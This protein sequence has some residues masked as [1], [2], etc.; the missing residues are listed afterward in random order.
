MINSQA[1]SKVIS[2]KIKQ[3]SLLTSFICG[4][5]AAINVNASTVTMT[6]QAESYSD[7]SGI[8]TETTT[9]TGGGLNVTGTDIGDWLVYPQVTMPCT[10]AYT[11]SYRV[12]ST[13]TGATLNLSNST[14]G[15]IYDSFTVPNTG[16]SQTWQTVTRTVSSLPVGGLKFKISVPAK[17]GW[18]LNYFK[19][20]NQCTTTNTARDTVTAM[21]KGF[22]LG[23]MF[24]KNSN[25]TFAQT[26][27]KID[28]YYAKGFR[29]VRVPI[30]WTEPIDGSLLA[31]PATG[32]VNTSN[33]RLGI[34]KQTVDYALSL[35]GM[36]VVINAHHEVGLKDN[37]RDWVLERLWLDIATIFSARNN[38]LL[39]EILNEPHLSS[40]AEMPAASL[41]T[42]TKK[43]Y[44][45]IRTVSLSR[46]VIIGGNQ[47]FKDFEV[48]NVW[49]TLDGL[50]NGND[51]Y[52]AATFHHYIPWSFCGNDQGDFTDAWTYKDQ[53]TPMDVMNNWANTVGNGMPVYIGEWGVA[54]GS[55]YTVM[56]CNNIR[57][58]YTSMHV[59]HAASRNQATAVWDD[60]GWFKIWNGSA[61]DN[62]LIDCIGGSCGWSSSNQLEGCY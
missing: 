25:T 49:T 57:K 5:S 26:K 6:L 8:S 14:T 2:K 1:V 12:A 33:T 55:R 62:N 52:I 58:W 23:N 40:G 16:G 41:R 21:G 7:M 46:V 47:W 4:V 27:A 48:P 22:N 20:T 24:D 60:G 45:K 28:A 42:M 13:V 51:A 53:Y 39:F 18:K 32:I 15:T 50:G 19:V 11:V 17:G 44:N 38:H 36:Y 54:W 10:G 34:I 29:N 43:A 61:W 30:T 59:T 37:N 35:S 3:L 31:D 56:N 9:D